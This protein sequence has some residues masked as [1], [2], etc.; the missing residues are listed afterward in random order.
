MLI[1]SARPDEY[2]AVGA[3][4]VAGYDNEGYLVMPDGSYDHRYAGWLGD[5]APRGQDGHLLVAVEGDEL[6][7]TVTWCPPGSLHR[8]VA[9][10][11]HHGEFRTLAVS[12][13]ARQRGVARQLVDECLRRA[14]ALNLTEMRLCSLP[15]MAPAHRLYESFGFV[16]RPELDWDP[17]P[18][19]HLWAFSAPLTD[20]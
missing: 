17:V 11:D 1:R 5:A 13:D 10:Q 9:T 12:P 20:D 2:D 14:R 4:T 6:L 15:T 16:R 7:G 18:G 19:V 8:E 3:L